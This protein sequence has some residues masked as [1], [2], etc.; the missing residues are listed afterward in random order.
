MFIA[1]DLSWGSNKESGF[2]KDGPVLGILEYTLLKAVSVK[3]G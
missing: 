2:G 3:V 1:S